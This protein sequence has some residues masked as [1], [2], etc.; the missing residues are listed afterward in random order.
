MTDAQMSTP[1]GNVVKD[2]SGVVRG[3]GLGMPGQDQLKLGVA[4]EAMGRRIQQV[5]QACTKCS[6]TDLF[7]VA[8]QAQNGPG[9]LKN[10][11][12]YL[13]SPQQ[14]IQPAS[15]NGPVINWPNWFGAEPLNPI[16]WFGTRYQLDL[17][18]DDVQSYKKRGWYVPDVDWKYIDKM[19]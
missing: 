17:F 14:R 3:Y 11:S 10:N 13:S 18:A 19:R 4:L 5:M 8:S 2:S 12:A 6:A 16:Y 9:F 15:P 7:L 1:Y